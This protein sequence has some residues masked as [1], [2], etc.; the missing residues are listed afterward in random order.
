ML[1]PA[2]GLDWHQH[3]VHRLR[4]MDWIVT[5]A[6]KKKKKKKIP[7]KKPLQPQEMVGFSVFCVG[8]NEVFSTSVSRKTIYCMR[9]DDGRICTLMMF[10][11][12][13]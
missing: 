6:V 8:R 7:K 1:A 10:N 3:W 11:V 9:T 5:M 4:L 2:N 13:L 12:V